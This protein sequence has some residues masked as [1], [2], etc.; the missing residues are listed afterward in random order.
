MA[1]ACSRSTL[2]PLPRLPHNT[3]RTVL[4][5]SPVAS[6]TFSAMCTVSRR[7]SVAGRRK[8]LH[9][10]DGLNVSNARNASTVSLVRPST[11]PS[12]RTSSVFPSPPLRTIRSLV[13][14]RSPGT[15]RALVLLSTMRLRYAFRSPGA[16]GRPVCVRTCFFSCSR[17]PAGFPAAVVF[18]A[19][20]AAASAEVVEKAARRDAWDGIEVIED[21]MG[22]E[23]R[24]RPRRQM[25]GGIVLAIRGLGARF[26]PLPS[27]RYCNNTP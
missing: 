21:S 2:L 4:L 19:G 10:C 25:E 7:I 22:V 6:T 13:K 24:A 15:S 12:C 9:P 17:L 23:E 3:F 20:V 16:T 8:R 18:F 5:L 27:C 11:R 1:C 14:S 26:Q